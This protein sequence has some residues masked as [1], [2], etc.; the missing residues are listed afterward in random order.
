MNFID[1]CFIKDFDESLRRSKDLLVESSNHGFKKIL[2]E[3]DNK[4]HKVIKGLISGKPYKCDDF[5]ISSAYDKKNQ[6]LGD[7]KMVKPLIEKYHIEDFEKTDPLN[8]IC[9][10]GYSPL[11][12]SWYGWSHRGIAGFHVGSKVSKGDCAY[13]PATK[14]DFI[15]NSK[16]FWESCG[17]KVKAKEIGKTIKI[18]F[19]SSGNGK[20]TSVINNLPKTFGKG[21]WTAK[22]IEDA[23]QMAKDYAKGVS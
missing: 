6:Y 15:E 19:I 10:I 21:E 9:T 12:K 8:T 4:T 7:P 14:K 23:K 20:E 11:E 2:S 13:Q 1:Y 5:E 22:T 18:S 3:K 16:K 17:S